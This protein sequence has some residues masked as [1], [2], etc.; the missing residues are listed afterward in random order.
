MFDAP[1]EHQLKTWDALVSLVKKRLPKNSD[2]NLLYGDL[3]KLIFGQTNIGGQS[4]G[5]SLGEI[6]HRT[7]KYNRKNQ[8]NHPP[9]NALVF[10]KKG[11]Q[12]GIPESR[13]PKQIWGVLKKNGPA[14][15]DRLGVLLGYRD[16][17]NNKPLKKK[18]KGKKRSGEDAGPSNGGTRSEATWEA[19]HSPLVKEIKLAV[20]NT[21]RWSLH[22]SSDW[23]P[24]IIFKSKSS[25]R[26]LL[27]EVK[28]DSSTHNIITA[29]GQVICYRS[30]LKEYTSIIAAPGMLLLSKKLCNV[31]R[32]SKIKSLDLDRN[33]SQ[34]MVALNI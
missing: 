2:E 34:Q 11:L 30:S 24:D 7:K 15:L 10:N 23:K 16:F 6:H 22:Q 31:M 26:I 17:S 14:Y 13:D 27:I 5:G 28:P 29:V 19:R 21:E 20:L 18:K 33:V 9:I 8:T 25:N 32:D 3:S 4:F 12:P 1:S